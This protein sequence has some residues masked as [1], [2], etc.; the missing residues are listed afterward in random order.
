MSRPTIEEVQEAYTE[1]WMRL[2]GVVGTG[3]GLCEGEPCIRVF[4]SR[5][6]PEA[7]DA[8]PSRVEGYAV[9]LEVTGEVEPR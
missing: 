4:L 9:D 5:P 8:I 1:R 6:S 2:P 7:R 3:I